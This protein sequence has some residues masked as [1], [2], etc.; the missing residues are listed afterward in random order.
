MRLYNNTSQAIYVLCIGRS[1]APKEYSQDFNI[2]NLFH[3][4]IA[5]QLIKS[6]A[7][8]C[9]LSAEEREL[10]ESILSSSMPITNKKAI[11]T[12]KA[13]SSQKPEQSIPMN[14]PGTPPGQVYF[15]ETQFVKPSDRQNDQSLAQEAVSTPPAP[16]SGK[17]A[18]TPEILNTPLPKQLT[19][20]YSNK[21]E[22]LDP[23]SGKSAK[24]PEIL[25]APIDP[26]TRQPIF[27]EANMLSNERSLADLDNEN[28]TVAVEVKRGRGR[29]K[30]IQ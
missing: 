14:P 28:T 13:V 16:D 27:N 3:N 11:N 20:I 21:N 8:K 29:P 1:L 30:K 2:R 5:L 6:R 22:A 18:K 7:L 4:P 15:G 17:L 24:I 23:I 12:K 19:S 10:F 26:V 25:T 9:V